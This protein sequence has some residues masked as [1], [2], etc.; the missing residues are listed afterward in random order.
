MG[1]SECQTPLSDSLTNLCT[2]VRNNFF[3]VAVFFS[4]TQQAIFISLIFFFFRLHRS[5]NWPSSAMNC[6]HSS[7]V[8]V[9]ADSPARNLKAI[10]VKA[11]KISYIK[12]VCILKCLSSYSIAS[13]SSLVFVNCVF[14]AVTEV[15]C[16]QRPTAT[17]EFNSYNIFLVAS[18]HQL[19]RTHTHEEYQFRN[20]S[21]MKRV[22]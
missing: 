16:C 6:L 11:W 9:R 10:K 4:S 19:T 2:R 22:D 8:V 21:C 14:I 20:G 17:G 1:V 3:S 7:D 5:L 15:F 13:S 12:M 18:L